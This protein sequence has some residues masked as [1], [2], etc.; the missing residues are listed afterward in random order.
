M[1]RFA[2][3]DIRRSLQSTAAILIVLSLSLVGPLLADTLRTS[4]ESFLRENSRRVLTA[5][6]AISSFRPILEE[7]IARVAAHFSVEKTA[8]EIEFASMVVGRETQSLLVEVHAIDADFPLV[9]QFEFAA[10]ET[11]R[12]ELEEGAVW[13]SREAATALGYQVGDQLKIGRATYRISRLLTATPG[14]SRT[15]FGLAPRAYLRRAGVEATG[16]FGVGS[17]VQ[18][19][20]YFT[21]SGAKN[22]GESAIKGVLLDP[23]LFVRTPD[24]S[25]QGL[26]RFTDAVSLYLA[27]VS[28]CLFALGWFA[29]FYIIRVQA[30][31]RVH[32]AV[33]AM[34]FGATPRLLIGLELARVVLMTLLASLVALV[35]VQ[36][37]MIPLE[38][39][40]A[41][42]I[43]DQVAMPF[44]L[45]TSWLTIGLLLVVSL[46]SGVLFTLPFAA[47]LR[48]SRLAQLFAESAV[49]ANVGETE[50][51][52]RW[53]L[54][55]IIGLGVF[56]LLCA[57]MVRLT[58]NGIRGLQITALFALTTMLL[59]LSGAWLFR[60]VGAL[61]QRFSSLRLL[62]IQLS[63][64]RFVVRLSFL[65][66][67]LSTFVTVVI[68]Q[69]MLSLGAEFREVARLDSLPDFFAFNI[70]EA[71]LERLS[72]WSQ[73]QGLQLKHLSPMILARFTKKNEEPVKGERFERFP[74]RVTWREAL[75]A[76]ETIVAG[77]PLPGRYAP[78]STDAAS[79]TDTP[80]SAPPEKTNDAAHLGQQFPF[81]SVESRFAE[82]SGLKLGDRLEFDVQGVPVVAI[83]R[84]F[85]RVRWADFNPNFF[86]SFQAGVLE[87]APKTWLA[88]L[89]AVDRASRAKLQAELV[90][91]FPD[92]SVI[93][94][95]QTLERV[96][97]IIRA[98]LAPAEWAAAVTALFSLL[99]LATVVGHSTEL[100]A[101][102]MGLLRILGAEPQRVR[103][104]YR[105][106]FVVAGFMGVL[107]GASLG[108]GA[109][110]LLLRQ[111]FDLSLNLDWGRLA[112]AVLIPVFAMALIGDWL[113]FRVARGLGFTRRF[114]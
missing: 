16:L 42:K 62:G 30:I 65:A 4:V 52:S 88:N 67:A 41:E 51:A 85:R 45:R 9:G 97:G 111:F 34:V 66:I 82:Q 107:V 32:R 72:A 105:A 103:R 71:E 89:R 21:F 63:R 58:G 60:G 49:Q 96:T 70:P 31:S 100:R 112:L 77:E 14:M 114:V 29:A 1:N 99:V 40:L 87:D 94:V 57:V 39:W 8:R 95:S 17:Q 11:G 55:F 23:D 59:V 75:L 6:I 74:V 109:T 98:V 78:P 47:R 84:N 36:L 33:V 46:A 3:T 22:V 18:H 37:L 48:S 101:R 64:S 106:E 80:P 24:D 2:V 27:L 79:S 26:E 5:D 56:G 73:A 53:L 110:A 93:D 54:W 102:E 20:A 104:L 113:Y 35:F 38:P 25:T 92:L 68:G 10:N 108:V 15:P 81:I 44:S 86:I 61:G 91:N 28:V 50:R 7:E 19:R 90:R 13:L 12:P 69:T 76:S 43:M 83:I